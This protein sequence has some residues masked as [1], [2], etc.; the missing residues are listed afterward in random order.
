MVTSAT[1]FFRD[2]VISGFRRSPGIART[3]GCI[4]ATRTIDAAACAASSA[5]ADVLAVP[6]VALVRSFV[7]PLVESFVGSSNTPWPGP[8]TQREATGIVLRTCASARD[9]S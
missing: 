1:G 7:L 8:R 3:P 4:G 9:T 2:F 5:V 6:E